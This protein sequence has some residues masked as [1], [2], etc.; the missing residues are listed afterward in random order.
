MSK[1]DKV[2]S[3]GARHCCE[4]AGGAIAAGGPLLGAGPEFT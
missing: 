2:R 4:S 1:R 3:F